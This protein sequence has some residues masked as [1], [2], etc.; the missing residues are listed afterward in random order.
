V[1]RCKNLWRRLVLRKA[2]TEEWATE[3]ASLASSPVVLRSRKYDMRVR[4]E[5]GGWKRNVLRSSARPTL[6]EVDCL[7]LLIEPV[8]RQLEGT[9]HNQNVSRVGFP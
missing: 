7:Q 4:L 9:V 3:N 8:Q 2:F 6:P 5:R 1:S